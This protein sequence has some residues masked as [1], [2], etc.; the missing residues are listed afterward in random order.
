MKGI[1]SCRVRGDGD[2]DTSRA[3]GRTER[4]AR[5]GAQRKN[6]KAE[7]ARA[8]AERAG[9]LPAPLAVSCSSESRQCICQC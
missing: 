2:R 7:R 5:R 9:V 6:A 3:R 8:E 4:A 1:S